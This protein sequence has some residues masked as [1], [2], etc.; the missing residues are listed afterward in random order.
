MADHLQKAITAHHE[1]AHAVAAHVLGRRVIRIS[2]AQDEYEWY[3]QAKTKDPDGIEPTDTPEY[4][5]IVEQAC[6]EKLAGME[7][8]RLSGNLNRYGPARYQDDLEIVHKSL[9]W[10]Y[11]DSIAQQSE[12]RELCVAKAAQLV[13][14]HEHDIER[15]GAASMA[16]ETL[17][18]DD[19]D[20]LLSP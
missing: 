3:G 1:A 2:I 8:E 9:A 12:H 18:G 20:R 6:I 7:W 11:P 4:H 10:V 17:E 16:A 5:R 13:K 19:L 15:V 14:D